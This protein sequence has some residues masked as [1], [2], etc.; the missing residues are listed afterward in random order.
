M[1]NE[2]PLLSK[3]R[4]P[5]E[6]FQLPSQGIFYHNG[7]LD[8]SS[9]NGEVEVY[10]MTT[11]DEIVFNTPDKLL[12]GKAIVEVFARCIPQI[13]KPLDLVSKDIDFLLVCLRM[14]TFGQTMD[15]NYKHDCEDDKY[16]VYQIDL[17]KLIRTTTKFDP[18]SIDREY[19]IKLPNGQV[20]LIKPMV[21]G[22]IL[23]VY[24]MTV[25]NKNQEVDDK[26]AEHNILHMMVSLIDS[27]DGITDKTMIFDWL[28]QLNLGWKKL[29][30][31]QITGATD[32][33]VNYDTSH[34][35]KSCKENI[36]IRLSANPVDFFFQR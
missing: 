33:G 28:K 11:I 4:I 21:Y 12:S 15:V 1:T 14:T 13:K 29:I 32:W 34:K 22:D 2:N 31:Q 19:T 36:T 16:H 3:I 35:C 8:P 27:V 18:T 30:E 9:T 7:E 25:T 10:P 17:Q 24:D 26:A 5:G 6:T 23:K 20:V